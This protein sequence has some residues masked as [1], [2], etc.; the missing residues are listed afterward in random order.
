[1]LFLDAIIVLVKTVGS[2]NVVETRDLKWRV[3]D[4]NLTQIITK[5]IFN[6]LVVYGYGL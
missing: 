6:N 3:I 4:L 5:K 1:M 2:L